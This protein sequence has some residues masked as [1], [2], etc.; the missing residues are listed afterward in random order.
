[1]IYNSRMKKFL[2][3]LVTASVAALTILCS[4]NSEGENSGF[5]RDFFAMSTYASLCA[6][7]I[8]KADFEALADEVGALL[9]AADRSLSVSVSTSYLSKFN[10]AAAGATLEI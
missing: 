7:K 3:G 6:D 5:K 2:T 10:T 8:E 1:M 4:C 9:Y